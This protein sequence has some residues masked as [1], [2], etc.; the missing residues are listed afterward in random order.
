MLATSRTS[1]VIF[2]TCCRV[3]K[4]YEKN[5]VMKIEQQKTSGSGVGVGLR[6]SEVQNRPEWHF[7]SAV[8]VKTCNVL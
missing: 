1:F 8:I 6:F 4:N 3:K 7:C 2:P 5:C